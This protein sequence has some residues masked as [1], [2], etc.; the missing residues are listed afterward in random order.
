[1]TIDVRPTA[2]SS[3]EPA[4]L[5][6]L[7]APPVSAALAA[8]RTAWMLRMSL[9]REL[10]VQGWSDRALLCGVRDRQLARPR[11]GA[12]SPYDGFVALDRLGRHA[13]TS[14]AVLAQADVPVA[15]SHLSAAV[16]FGA[17]EWGLDLSEVH[18]TRFD[19]R[20]GRREA[21]VVQHRG[22]LLPGDLVEVHGLPMVS[23]TRAAIELTTAVDT[24]VGLAQVNH[25]LHTR[26]TTP[27]ALR[28]R[29]DLMRDWPETLRTEIVL[30]LADP[31]IESVLESRF[32]HFCYRNSLPR[33]EPQ[34][35]VRCDETGDLLAC[36]DF[37]WKAGRRRPK[38]AELD[39]KVKYGELLRPGQTAADVVL[40]EK[41]RD[42]MVKRRTGMDGERFRWADLEPAREAITAERVRRLL[43]DD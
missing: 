6:L 22:A 1:M 43:A 39:G 30:R 37:V 10:V 36:L 15:L 42:K 31:R 27:E 21:G 41:E 12:Y 34:V 19:R 14:R 33:P 38:Y 2:E 35:E 11:R 16:W 28:E 9:R 24:E 29:L 23:P 4:P 32:V 8:R 3:A 13:V 20:S 25:L 5:V 18:V 17:P 7:P 40:R 26:Q